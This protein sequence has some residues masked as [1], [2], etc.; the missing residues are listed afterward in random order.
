MNEQKLE[1]LEDAF[2]H[3]D[4]VGKE[5]GF[6][7]LTP[8]HGEW[9]HEMVFGEGDYTLQAHRGSYKSSCL[10]VAIALI[11][12]M[13]PKRNIIFIRKTDNDVS[14]MLGM[15]A[16]I[17]RTGLM[18]DF[19]NFMH[20]KPLQIVSEG[21][22]HISTNLWTSPMGAHQLLGIGLRASITGKH[23]YY[24][25]TD[26]ICNLSDRISRAE[27][28]RTKLQ[29]DELQN[30]RNREGRIINLGTPWHK[31]DVFSKMP[32]IHRYDCYQTGLIST[33]K[34]DEIRQSM[35]PSLFAANYE[36]KHI[37]SEEAF[38]DTP[39]VFTD[40]PKQLR[41]GISHI[42]AAYGGED[43]TAFTIGFQDP[44]TEEIYLYGR[45]WHK[46]VQKVLPQIKEDAERFEIWKI[47]CEDNGDKGFLRDLILSETGI[48]SSSYHESQ[49]KRLKILTYLRQCW[50]RIK[51]LPGTDPAYI[52][53]IMDFTETAEHDDAPDSAAT[54]CRFFTTYRWEGK[55]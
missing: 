1:M 16:K 34:L 47:C 14:E 15:V 35:T 28:E 33:E 46:N 31:D 44:R 7:D 27:R 48:W 54:I 24:V 23:A 38:F 43:Y 49:N 4:E 12:L 41:N 29:Y 18:K 9:I 11:L 10:A 52:R 20:G 53:Q 8:L 30:I 19:C 42:D 37:A 32:N 22:D 21:T 40:D 45:L 25:I 13:N 6:K 3:L 55:S 17:L 51:F 26:D 2:S 36:L 39:P 50:P 5:V